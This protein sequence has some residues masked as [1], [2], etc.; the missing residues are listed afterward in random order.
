MLHRSL[1]HR[2]VRLH[3]DAILATPFEAQNISPT[4]HSES[5]GQDPCN[6]S[7]PKTEI[8]T[9]NFHLPGVGLKLLGP[10]APAHQSDNFS[11]AQSMM[12]RTSLW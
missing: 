9:V 3:H 11:E 2:D 1:V 5:R 7:P 6:L 12:R 4:T 10:H 8:V